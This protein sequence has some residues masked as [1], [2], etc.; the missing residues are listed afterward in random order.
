MTQTWITSTG[1]HGWEQ[2]GMV[3]SRVASKIQAAVR[4]IIAVLIIAM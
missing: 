3:T 1:T 4:Q 2:L